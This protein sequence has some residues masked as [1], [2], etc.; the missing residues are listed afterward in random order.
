MSKLFATTQLKR[1]I[2]KS[3]LALAL[4]I[5]GLMIL[6][7]TY[8]ALGSWF[9]RQTFVPPGKLY[10]VD[11]YQLHLFCQG[12]GKPIVILESG[13]SATVAMW[14]RIQTELAKTTQVCAYDR[15]GIGWSESNS[16]EP[17]ADFVVQ[18]LYTLL[19]KAGLQ[20]P[21]ILVG[22]SMGGL[23]ARA[24]TAT[25]PKQI[26]GLVLLDAVHP[27]QGQGLSEETQTQQQQ[28][29]ALL[30]WTPT[31]A[32]LGVLRVASWFNTIAEELP[33]RAQAAHQALLITP[34]HLQATLDEASQWEKTTAQVR[35][36]QDLNDIPLL[37]I[38]AGTHEFGF[39]TQGIEQ[40]QTLQQD[41]T[42]LSDNSQYK[43]IPQA[44]HHSLLT[45][46]EH[47]AIGVAA[48]TRLV[49]QVRTNL[50]KTA[51]GAQ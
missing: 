4:L 27:D 8:Q 44:T 35:Q 29:M 41:L 40:W 21:F 25:F 34:K 2:K 11:G 9:D 37:V 24:Y 10:D 6:G 17:D 20:E 39:G 3:L 16:A 15:A 30:E 50:N 26:A 48:I 23:F 28:F 18:Q 43:L 46:P 47:A 49:Q 36:Q 38:S 31:L 51:K 32:R 13:L 19:N 12:Q 22:H 45:D 42:R 7:T 1:W 33:N 14:T 5:L